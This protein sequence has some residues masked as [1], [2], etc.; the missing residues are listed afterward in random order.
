MP[1]YNA[2]GACI[3]GHAEPWRYTDTC[4]CVECSATF[5]KAKDDAR[6]EMAKLNAAGCPK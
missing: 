4:I 1:M 2:T 3:H 6:D 5:R